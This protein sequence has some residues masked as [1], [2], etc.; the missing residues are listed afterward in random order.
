MALESMLSGLPDLAWLSR[1]LQPDQKFL[2]PS[3]YCIVINYTFT[4]YTANVFGYFLS[5][6]P[7]SNL[8]NI[9]SKIRLYCIFICVAFK[10]HTEWSNAQCVSIPITI[11]L[12]TLAVTFHSFE[13]LWSLKLAHTKILLSP[14]SRGCNIFQ[15]HLCKEMSVLNYIWWW[16]SSSSSYSINYYFCCAQSFFFFLDNICCQIKKML[17]SCFF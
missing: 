17:W 3:G 7:S 8:K 15:L 2:Q 5:L 9:T 14:V 13:L 16:G 12:P 1:F 4:F 11:I 6:W 10:S